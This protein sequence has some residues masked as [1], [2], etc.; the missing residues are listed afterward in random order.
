MT[1]KLL[2]LLMAL[3]LV[4]SL[5]PM[6]ALALEG[7]VGIVGNGSKSFGF[8]VDPA[9]PEIPAEPESPAEGEAPEETESPAVESAPVEQAEIAA[10][11]GNAHVYSTD[12]FCTH[13]AQGSAGHYQ[14]AV[15]ASD[16]V[17]EISNAGQMFWYAALMN[18]DSSSAD[19][20]GYSRGSA[21]L[22]GDIDL[23]SGIDFNTNGP[24][25]STARTWTGFALNTQVF[26]G[27]GH[28]IS[29][30]WGT[31]GFITEIITS[32]SGVA[33]LKNLTITNSCIKNNDSTG[34]VG[35]LCNSMNMGDMENCH[36]GAD[37]WV[38]ATR[39]GVYAGGICGRTYNADVIGCTNAATVSSAD[40][41]AGIVA[42]NEGYVADGFNSG[43]ITG[44]YAGGIC[45]QHSYRASAIQYCG[46]IGIILADMSAGGI[47]AATNTSGSSTRI[48]RCFNRGSVSVTGES[49]KEWLPAYAGGIAGEAYNNTG[50]A[51]IDSCY[52]TGAVTAPVTKP[53][54]LLGMTERF[55]ALNSYYLSDTPVDGFRSYG[56]TAAQFD[57][58]MVCYELNGK[59]SDANCT[60]RQ[61][62]DIEDYPDFSGAIVYAKADGSGY[63]NPCSTHY[64]SYSL[65]DT[66]I[67]EACTVC[68]HSATATLSLVEGAVSVGDYS[69]N[70]LSTQN[71]AIRY[72]GDNYPSS[73]YPPSDYGYYTASIVY[74]LNGEGV[75][76]S[77]TIAPTTAT[78]A[79]TL[80]A[81]AQ[82][83]AYGGSLLDGTDWVELTAG[84]LA[85]GHRLDSVTLKASG[86]Q[87][88]PSAAVILDAE[89]R[90]VTADYSIRYTSGS[91]S[92][93]LTGADILWGDV[94]CDAAVDSLDA[95]LVLRRAAAIIGDED[96]HMAK[97]DVD[98]SGKVD[99]LD[100]AMILRYAAGI[101]QQFPAESK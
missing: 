49:A 21:R 67:T 24:V 55:G 89:G 66:T 47:T 62:L 69:D 44:R 97:A 95:A 64:L 38:T 92:V 58:G 5:F 25:G 53:G 11:D 85:D 27:Q 45:G 19:L 3:C 99:A 72:F 32:G 33:M 73:V 80:R 8:A 35:A 71:P 52:N 76:Y 94:N 46:N 48:L 96:L 78:R 74:G 77:Y 87:I 84:S 57:S 88:T 13:C 2:S 65:Q 75:S 50:S 12:G 4:F 43:S 60:W 90:D 15:C 91:L 37:V 29:G 86:G 36:T 56:R 17:Y 42:Y 20:A 79:I 82:T 81:K 40:Y 23:N 61:D 6:T 70:W 39:S 9:E 98:G 54:V 41:A 28:S 68:D 26:D 51:Y 59:R 63:Y 14:P 100:A 22:T 30:L 1:K 83:I 16:G 10:A 18:D 34:S 7:T 101:I 31:G 93:D